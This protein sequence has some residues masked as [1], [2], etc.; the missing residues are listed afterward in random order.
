MPRGYL[1]ADNCGR[2]LS[3]WDLSPDKTEGGSVK[4]PETALDR[5]EQAARQAAEKPPAWAWEI[6]AGIDGLEARVDGLIVRVA[7]MEGVSPEDQRSL[8]SLVAAPE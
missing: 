2:I 8:L 1:L 5:F 3:R 6:A 7:K 4:N